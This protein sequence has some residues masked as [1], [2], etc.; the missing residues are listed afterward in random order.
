MGGKLAWK[1]GLLMF[2]MLSVLSS[3]GWSQVGK[4][5]TFSFSGVIER[6]DEPHGFIVVNEARI[7][8]SGETDLVDDR[9][10][11]LQPGDLRR[12]L[13]VALEVLRQPEGFFAKKVIV[14]VLRRP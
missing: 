11:V 1:I 3:P 10:T 8:I 13:P 9:G 7:F 14:K 12:G 4:E 5:Q 2:A 6:V